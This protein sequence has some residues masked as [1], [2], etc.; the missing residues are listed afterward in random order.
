MGK[1]AVNMKPSHLKQVL[2]SSKGGITLTIHR[3]PR[4]A[5]HCPLP[6]TECPEYYAKTAEMLPSP[7]TPGSGASDTSMGYSSSHSLPSVFST[8][9]PPVAKGNKDGN[10]SIG[11]RS[12]TASHSTGYDTD[13]S[14]HQRPNSVCSLAVAGTTGG[15]R[16]AVS[17]SPALTLHRGGGSNTQF[18]QL[19]V[20]GVRPLPPAT[21]STPTPSLL[22]R[23]LSDVPGALR[24]D[25]SGT[26]GSSLQFSA[27]GATPTLLRNPRDESSNYCSSEEQQ[28]GNP[29]KQKP[30]GEQQTC[31]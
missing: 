6:S 22:P 20:G 29:Q 28:Q 10:G 27:R 4:G 30:P 21:P 18:G 16:L 8:P 14:H 3:P 9:G 13:M 17:G 12:Q 19:S 5:L 31:L 1:S 2:K 23:N 24:G 26:Q 7:G 15:S 11:E 25:L